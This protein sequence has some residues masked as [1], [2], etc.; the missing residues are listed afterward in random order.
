MRLAN[1]ILKLTLVT[2]VIYVLVIVQGR[3]FFFFLSQA[4]IIQENILLGVLWLELK[5]GRS[6]FSRNNCTWPLP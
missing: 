6:K 4:F 1:L 2:A 3:D 5:L